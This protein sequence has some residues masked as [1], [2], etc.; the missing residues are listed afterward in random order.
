MLD[1]INS[2]QSLSKLVPRFNKGS[3]LEK[4]EENNLENEEKEN[5]K[6]DKFNKDSIK[7]KEK[8]EEENGE[9]EN[10]KNEDDLTTKTTIPFFYR[11]P[12]QWE[13]WDRYSMDECSLISRQPVLCNQR[14][15]TSSVSSAALTQEL[16]DRCLA[17]SNIFRGFSFLGEQ[18]ILSQHEGL[19][20]L[21]AAILMLHCSDQ[22]RKRTP[23]E[24]WNFLIF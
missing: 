15:I 11:K 4:D 10:K 20:R 12:L 8:V 18:K 17:L 24:V 3:N 19:L 21:L 23:G 22:S 14:S 6:E 16:I 9:N 1:H 2:R 5:L 13:N 7:K